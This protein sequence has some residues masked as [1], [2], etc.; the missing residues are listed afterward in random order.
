MSGK[1]PAFN[2]AAEQAE[3]YIREFI[4]YGAHLV[5]KEQ[6]AFSVLMRKHASVPEPVLI[7]YTT[8]FR[9]SLAKPFLD[10]KVGELIDAAM[11][12]LLS[13]SKQLA[14]EHE[15]AIRELANKL[16]ANEQE[17]MKKLKIINKVLSALP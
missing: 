13:F 17:T 3:Y 7:N 11:G 9:K 8:A 1:A 16:V 15:A 6:P 14:I 2:N 4:D 10:H 12:L 5:E